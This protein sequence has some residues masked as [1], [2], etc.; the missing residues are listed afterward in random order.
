MQKEAT[1][2][3][4]NPLHLL[5]H[6]LTDK[7]IEAAPQAAAAAFEPLAPHEILMLVKSLKA[8]RLIAL[9]NQMATPKGAAVFRR[10]P[11]KQGAYVLSRLEV[12]NAAKLW[13][14][15]ATP[16]Q[17]SLKEYLA[18][19]FVKLLMVANGLGQQSVGK[20]LQTDFVAV[21]TEQKVEEL[22]S[23]LKN[24]PRAEIPT[25]C[26]ITGKNDDLKGIIRTVELAFFN[27]QAV[28]GSVMSKD[29]ATLRPQDTLAAAQATFKQAQTDLLPVVDEKKL[30]LG[31]LEKSA[32]LSAPAPQ[33]S[34][35]KR[36]KFW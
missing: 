27:P 10:L 14:E 24:L 2:Q 34:G 23:R 22:I 12:P 21:K 31:V 35:W 8:Q 15:F 16:Y 9:F 17:E 7:F 20:F 29:F 19:G 1:K 28:C 32:V 4:A 36:L 5:V 13:K 26:L 11:F 33:K 3:A 6:R 30:L 25:L 18:P